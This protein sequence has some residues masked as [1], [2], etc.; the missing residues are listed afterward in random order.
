MW[1]DL[2]QLPRHYKY[3]F[4]FISAKCFDLCFLQ[5]DVHGLITAFY[6]IWYKLCVR[7]PLNKMRVDVTIFI[8]FYYLMD[9]LLV[10]FL[11]EAVI[12]RSLLA[13]LGMGDCVADTELYIKVAPTSEE[14]CITRFA[15]KEVTWLLA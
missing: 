4:S 10:I 8:T 14:S 9:T 6:I 7:V 1:R 15:S 2:S 3:C 12:S 5:V 11:T 13:A